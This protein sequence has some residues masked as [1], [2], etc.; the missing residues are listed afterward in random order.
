MNKIGQA[1]LGLLEPDNQAQ[2]DVVAELLKGPVTKTKECANRA[3]QK[4]PAAR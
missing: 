3:A 2:R 1:M 4:A